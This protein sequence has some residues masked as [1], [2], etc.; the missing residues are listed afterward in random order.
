MMVS[1]ILIMTRFGKPRRA[2]VVAL[3]PLS[4]W[5]LVDQARVID[6]LGAIF[7][8][9]RLYFDHQVRTRQSPYLDR[10]AG[11]ERDAQIVVPNIDVSKELIDIGDECCGFN[12]IG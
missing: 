11:R 1:Q 10:G 9:D 7:D 5:G 6:R 2:V 12:Q 3:S 4:R 8:S